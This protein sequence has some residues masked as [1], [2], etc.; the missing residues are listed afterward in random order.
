MILKIVIHNVIKDTFSKAKSNQI[1]IMPFLI[2]LLISTILIS[3]AGMINPIMIIAVI[4]L[5]SVFL[6]GWFNMF[7]AAVNEKKEEEPE[8]IKTEKKEDE[9]T[10]PLSLYGEFFPGVGKY[11]WNFFNGILFYLILFALLIFAAEML[12]HQI[13]G[14]MSN[15]N[16]Y[17]KSIHTL[18]S[19]PEII[20][21]VLKIPHS[22]KIKIL[23]ILLFDFVFIAIYSVFTMFWAQSLICE[24]K[25]PIFAFISSIKTVAKDPINSILIYILAIT[26][27]TSLFFINYF[28]GESII[29]QLLV[30]MLLA[31]IIVYNTM[32]SFI[33]FERYKQNSE[34][35]A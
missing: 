35:Q 27:F 29:G 23:K 5:K 9:T 33:Y 1:L 30:L 3:P 14:N 26:S 18:H 12:A 32:I 20:N 22:E 24:N 19:K 16:E 8:V 17:S 13:I 10:E 34:K 28:I 4:A 21:F 7:H 11:F 6:S 2:F 31:Y 25:N 15:L